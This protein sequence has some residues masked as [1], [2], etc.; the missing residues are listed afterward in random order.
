[1]YQT[2]DKGPAGGLIDLGIA[3]SVKVY[4]NIN[5]GIGV[6][7]CYDADTIEIDVILI[8]AKIPEKVVV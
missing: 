5:N 7:G 8:V 6:L 3:G 4:F 1:L 2:N